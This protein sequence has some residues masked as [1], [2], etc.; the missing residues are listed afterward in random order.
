MPCL[1]T[2]DTLNPV[3]MYSDFVYGF[4]VLKKEELALYNKPEWRST[5]ILI[6]QSI[7]LVIVKN[8]ISFITGK[9]TVLLLLFVKDQNY[10]LT[11]WKNS[12][13]RKA[14]S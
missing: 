3:P 4:Q 13:Q 6:P 2:S 10:C 12:A 11:C 8:K 5:N 7:S 14:S 9:D 1:Q